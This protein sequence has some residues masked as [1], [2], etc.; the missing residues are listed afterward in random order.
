[1]RFPA[2]VRVDTWIDTGTEVTPLYDPLLAKVLVAGDDRAAAIAGLGG[3]LAATEVAGVETNREWVRAVLDDPRFAELPARARHS[4]ELA[5]LIAGRLRED[6][7]A[8]WRAVLKEDGLPHG[9][10]SP[11]PWA[12]L[13]HPDA[14]ALGLVVRV[15]DPTLGTETVTG[16]PLRLS[17][18]PARVA[19]RAGTSARAISPTRRSNSADCSSGSSERLPL[20]I[21]CDASTGSL[22]TSSTRSFCQ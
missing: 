17:R 3:A 13:D 15:E 5:E 10:V 16:P 18:T 21:D 6:T 9:E 11:T 14:A 22:T 2:G 12:V 4:D 8:A 19:S 20:S 7:T 1:M